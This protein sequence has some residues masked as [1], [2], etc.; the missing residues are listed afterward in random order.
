MQHGLGQ[1]LLHHAQGHAHAGGDLPGG[2]SMYLGL[3]EGGARFFRQAAEPLADLHQR[4]D[5]QRLV[6][7]GRGIGFRLGR[8]AFQPS[9]LHFP[10]SP[11]IGA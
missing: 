7:R 2:K 3:E 10:P 6:F 5:D 9:L 11:E 4:F 8:K 1:V